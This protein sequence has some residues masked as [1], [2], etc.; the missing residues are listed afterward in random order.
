MRWLSVIIAV[1]VI[2]FG[3]FGH[4]PEAHGQAGDGWITLIDGTTGLENWDR[5]GDANWRAEDDAIVADKGTSGFLVSKSSYKDFQIRAEFWAEDTTNSGVYFRCTDRTMIANANAYEANI[6]DQRPDPS[7]GTGAL[8]DV[9]TVPPMAYKAGG[10]WNTYEITANGPLQTAVLNGVQTA[11]GQDSRFEQGAIGLQYGAG[12]NNAV[13]G[14]IK[15][16]KV[17][18]RLL[19][20]ASPPAQPA[21]PSPA[22][23]QP[24]APAPASAQPAAP[25]PAPVQAPVRAPVQLPAPR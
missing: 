10:K 8:V 18:I 23:A 4:V 25:A 19:A 12:P 9:G 3:V 11:T 13:G 16:R 22:P 2:G 20:Q 17:Q 1:L 14:A 21:A 15:W 5:I 24:A 6:Y 7:Y